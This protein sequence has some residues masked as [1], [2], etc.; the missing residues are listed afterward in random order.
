MHKEPKKVDKGL[1]EIRKTIYEQI[2]NNS[3]KRQKLFFRKSKKNQNKKYN[4]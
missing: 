2:E 3:N 4:H 1:K